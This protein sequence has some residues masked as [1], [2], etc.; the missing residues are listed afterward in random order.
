MHRLAC[1]RSYILNYWDKFKFGPC[2]LCSTENSS[3]SRCVTVL[4]FSLDNT[5]LQTHGKECI[6]YVADCVIGLPMN[7]LGNSSYP[8][9]WAF[10]PL[11]QSPM[12]V[13]FHSPN[14]MQIPAVRAAQRNYGMK[15]STNFEDSLNSLFPWMNVNDVPVGCNVI[16]PCLLWN[17]CCWIPIFAQIY[18]VVYAVCVLTLM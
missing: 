12:T 9:D 2:S 16:S 1:N 18:N 15:E 17:F 11:F 10:P 5:E 6:G 4:K 3:H 14:V 13:P 7:I 8:M